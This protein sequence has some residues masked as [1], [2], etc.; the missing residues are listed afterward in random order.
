MKLAK[1]IKENGLT[2]GQFADMAA[3]SRQTVWLLMNKNH[4]PTIKTID[5]IAKATKGNVVL[6]D[7][8]A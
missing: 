1:F 5:K 3:I 4:T 8:R 6:E 2:W 7:L